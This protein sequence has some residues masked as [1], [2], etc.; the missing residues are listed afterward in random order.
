M[1]REAKQGEIGIVIDGKYY[2]ITKYF[3]E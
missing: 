1:G 2:G 3:E